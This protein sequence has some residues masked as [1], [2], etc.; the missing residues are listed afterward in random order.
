MTAIYGRS[1]AGQDIPFVWNAAVGAVPLE[2][3]GEGTSP[4][5]YV[6][7]PGCP[8]SATRL[9]YVRQYGVEVVQAAC[10]SALAQ[11]DRNA[12]A[13]SAAASV[14]FLPFVPLV[15]FLLAFLVRALSFGV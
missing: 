1:P 13:A 2:R 6:T 14:A 9:R 3:V 5:Q 4:D 8:R 10:T 7:L 15:I 11:A 12:R